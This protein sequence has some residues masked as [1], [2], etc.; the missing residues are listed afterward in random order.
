MSLHAPRSGLL[1]GELAERFYL[2]FLGAEFLER[3]DAE[4]FLRFRPD[5]AME[6]LRKA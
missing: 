2:E 5:R 1:H 6:G 3:F 4:T